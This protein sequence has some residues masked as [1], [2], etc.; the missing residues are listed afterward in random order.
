MDTYQYLPRTIPDPVVGE[1]YYLFPVVQFF[2]GERVTVF[3]PAWA[4]QPL[5]PP[6][7]HCSLS[8]IDPPWPTPRQAFQDKRGRGGIAQEQ[9][10]RLPVLIVVSLEGEIFLSRIRHGVASLEYPAA[11]KRLLFKCLEMRA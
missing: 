4:D 9:A 3:P 2:D 7:S 6:P 8:L 10:V 11:E 5:T 1:G